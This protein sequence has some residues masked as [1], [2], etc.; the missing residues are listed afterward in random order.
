MAVNILDT[1]RPCNIDEPDMLI[2]HCPRTVSVMPWDD[3][4]RRFVEDQQRAGWIAVREPDAL[5][6]ITPMHPARRM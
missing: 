6:L 1:V 2:V 5:H 3:L 4:S